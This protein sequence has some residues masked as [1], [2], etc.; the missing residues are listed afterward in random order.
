LEDSDNDGVNDK[1]E[2]ET[3]GT[4]PNVRDSDNDGMI[5]GQEILNGTDPLSAD[6]DGDGYSDGEESQKSD[7]LD[8]NSIPVEEEEVK[9][10]CS[11]SAHP[12]E[13]LPILIL[14]GFVSLFRRKTKLS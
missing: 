11:T 7:P 14:L 10:G 4:N 2:V 13:S 6:S 5:D 12:I 8:P 3:Y 1:D 9:T